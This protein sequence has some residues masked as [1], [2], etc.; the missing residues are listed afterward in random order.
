LAESAA[1]NEEG[2]SCAPA[3]TARSRTQS[4]HATDVE[5]LGILHAFFSKTIT[6]A[7]FSTS[8]KGRRGLLLSSREGEKR[9]RRGLRRRDGPKI[10]PLGALL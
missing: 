2:T 10:L 5:G 1:P 6:V 9:R 4:P 3:A 7:E 8:P